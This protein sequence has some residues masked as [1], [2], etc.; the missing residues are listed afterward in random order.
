DILDENKISVKDNYVIKDGKFGTLKVTERPIGLESSSKEFIYN[1]EKRY[2]ED[3]TQ[4][5]SVLEEY[6]L[7]DGHK[8]TVVGNTQIRTVMQGEVE[9]ELTYKITDASGNDVTKNY[10]VLHYNGKL[11]IKPVEITVTLNDLVVIYGA[12]LYPATPNNYDLTNSSAL[13]GSE[14][15]QVAVKYKDENGKTLTPVN[16]GIYTIVLD[17]AGCHVETEYGENGFG[18]YTVL[19]ADE[20]EAKLTIITREITVELDPM[21]KAYGENF[22][23]SNAG[24]QLVSGEIVN[25]DDIKVTVYCPDVDIDKFTAVGEYALTIESCAVN[26]VHNITINDMPNLIHAGNYDITYVDSKLTVTAREI[27]VVSATAEKDGYYDGNPFSCPEYERAYFKGYDDGIMLWDN[28]EDILEYV[29]GSANSI[30][31]A[32]KVPNEAQ[33]TSKSDNYTVVRTE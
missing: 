9:N 17:L 20:V 14:Q 24:Y 13:V 6:G 33:F 10:N 1:G 27:V 5:E 11:K 8:I 32:V 19:N 28:I 15:L 7:V 30:T 26:G 12:G 23:G 22:D 25:D 16:V 21:T 29:D 31:N 2:C 4:L 18:N 3:Y